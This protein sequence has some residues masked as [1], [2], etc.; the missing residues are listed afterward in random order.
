M[1]TECSQ[2]VF[3]KIAQKIRKP[4]KSIMHTPFCSRWILVSDPPPRGRVRVKAPMPT[5]YVNIE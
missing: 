2:I 5:R 4:A 1:P 3:F